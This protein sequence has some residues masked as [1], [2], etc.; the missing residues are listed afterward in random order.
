MNPLSNLDPYT[1]FLGVEKLC[2]GL[3]RLDKG[4]IYTGARAQWSRLWGRVFLLDA[5]ILNLSSDDSCLYFYELCRF[6][7]G[8]YV[9]AWGRARSKW[10]MSLMEV[11]AASGFFIYD[12]SQLSSTSAHCYLEREPLGP[13]HAPYAFFIQWYI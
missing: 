8:P 6:L 10:F 4:F 1:R 3:S 13:S 7:K 5:M 11:V 12:L 2:W 9:C